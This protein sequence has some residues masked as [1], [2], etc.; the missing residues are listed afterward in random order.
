[1]Q[2]NFCK[3]DSVRFFATQYNPGNI[4]SFYWDFND[5]STQG[6]GSDLDTVYHFYTSAGNYSPVLTLKD[7]HDCTYTIEKQAPLKIYGP[8]AAFS[9][10]NGSCIIQNVNFVDESVSDGTHAITSWIWD[11]GDGSKSDTLTGPPF[12]HSYSKT[13]NYNVV[14]K[15]TD[16]NGCFDT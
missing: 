12:A 8:A 3:Y 5:G 16:N 10:V 15:V 11:Y 13:G 4:K 9:N 6:F 14:L 1:M 7:I 2:T